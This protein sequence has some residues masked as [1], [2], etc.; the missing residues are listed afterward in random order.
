VSTNFYISVDHIDQAGFHRPITQEDAG[1]IL[2]D[3]R[4]KDESGDASPEDKMAEISALCRQNTPWA[5]AKVLSR[6]S[7]SKGYEVPREG[8]KVLQNAAQGLTQELAFVLKIPLDQ[9]VLRVREC[10]RGFKSP[11]PQVEGALQR[12]D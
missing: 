12:V 10:L 2:K 5:F 3:L 11:N 6:L 9:A 7:Q 4:K 1:Q 8:R